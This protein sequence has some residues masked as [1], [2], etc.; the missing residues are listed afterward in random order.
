[1]LAVGPSTADGGEFGAHDGSLK[2]W[3]DSLRP[4]AGA[5]SIGP[6][7]ELARARGAAAGDI[8]IFSDADPA[9]AATGERWVRVGEPADNL[10][11]TVLAARRFPLEPEHGE[12]LAEVRNYGSTVAR[13]ELELAIAGR[14]PQRRAFDLGA[15][16]TQA[17]VFTVPDIAGAITGRLIGNHDALALDDERTTS[18]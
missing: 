6:A 1:V 17:V 12:V 16:S 10:A 13:A 11:I 18:C 14:P 15:R 5:A 7:I 8:F 3:L 2:R 4:T 9:H